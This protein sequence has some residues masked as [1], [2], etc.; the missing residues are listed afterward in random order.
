MTNTGERHPVR[1]IGIGNLFRGDDAVGLLAA[2]I[3]ILLS[4]I[5]LTVWRAERL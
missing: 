1:I 5:T 2:Q 3:V 4:L